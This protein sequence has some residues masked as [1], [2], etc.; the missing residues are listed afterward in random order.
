MTAWPNPAL[1]KFVASFGDELVFAQVLIQRQG[2]AY[3]LR[4]VGDR[5]TPET[6]L[7]VV[8][9]SNLREVAQTT[10]DGAFRP[11]KSAPNLR[12]G[13]RTPVSNDAELGNA[14][15]HLYP[16]AVADWFAVQAGSP[17]VTHYR[18]FTGRQTGMYRS[19]TLLND[20]QASQMTRACCHVRFCL[21]RRLWTVPG[22]AADAA[23][24]KSMIPCLEPCAVLLEFARKVLRIEQEHA[25]PIAGAPAELETIALESL[26][27][28]PSVELREADFGAARNPR[29]VQWLLEKL[30]PFFAAGR[31]AG[32]S[33]EEK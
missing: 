30:K 20:E 21:K 12:A 2:H 24:E 29:R 17:P 4:H 13:W 7:R 8:A 5:K 32:N 22:L 1:E 31:A 3:A 18:E 16:G 6:E 11:L 9:V 23:S 27:E 26:L 33:P 19:T 28:R 14:L 15:N 10:A 25:I